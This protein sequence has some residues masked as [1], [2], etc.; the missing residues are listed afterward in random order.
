MTTTMNHRQQVLVLL[1]F[2]IL[3][4]ILS[5][6]LGFLAPSTSTSRSHVLLSA[7]NNN[8]VGTK[9]DFE[10]QELKIVLQ[11]M[12]EQDVVSARLKDYKQTELEGYVK[13]IVNR[14]PSSIPLNEMGQHLPGTE[15]RL[16]F[17][18]QAL[19]NESLPKDALIKMTFHDAS[20]VDYG[21]EFTK[22][23]GLKRLAAKS[24]Y[25]VDVSTYIVYYCSQA[26]SSIRFR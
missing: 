19:T 2:T 5:T 11:A 9:A 20:H 21:L 12:K 1:A 24:S 4:A 16:A 26:L 22:T 18:T 13:K 7:V 6:T 10:Y 25:T 15:W 8:N 3:A 17:T 23:L 14:R